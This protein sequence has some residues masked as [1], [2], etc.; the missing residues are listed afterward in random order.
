M[1]SIKCIKY[2]I[3][4]NSRDICWKDTIF[5]GLALKN[6]VG[7]LKVYPIKIIFTAIIKI[8]L[9]GIKNQWPRQ[10]DQMLNC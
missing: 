2:F 6:C 8:Q 9:P 3:Q 4:S 10:K 5:D 1:D 7:K